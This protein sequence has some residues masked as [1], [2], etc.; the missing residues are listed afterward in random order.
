MA[1]YRDL[2]RT[3]DF[4]K[5]K[6]RASQLRYGTDL[7]A[8]QYSENL[9]VFKTASGTY[10]RRKYHVQKIKIDEDLLSFIESGKPFKDVESLIRDAKL[11][12]YCSCEAFLYWGFKYIAWKKGYGLEKETR[13]P[14][15]RNPLEQGSVCKHLRLVLSIYPFWAK[16]L[17]K[18]FI[19]HNK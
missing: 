13:R 17:A 18:N 14:I 1:T 16:S 11:K 7:V 4:L 8:I 6:E 12:V 5:V 10:G 9:L 19:N 2:L 15:V 3:R